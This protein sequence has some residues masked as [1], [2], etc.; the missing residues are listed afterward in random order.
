M[1]G[2]TYLRK[3]K[4][5][6]NE[7][8]LSADASLN[9]SYTITFSEILYMYQINVNMLNKIGCSLSISYIELSLCNAKQ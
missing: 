8:I 7:L 6:M 1:I 5:P 3:K 4:P 2:L 9:F